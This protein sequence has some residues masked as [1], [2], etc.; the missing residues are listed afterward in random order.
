MVMNDELNE[1]HQI[2]TRNIQEVLMH[3]EKLDQLS[4]M[5]SHLASE[6]RAYADKAGDLNRRQALI[7]EWPWAPV[8]VVLGVVLLVFWLKIKLY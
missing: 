3:G 1:V 4:Q 7:R 8:A 6:T 5:T 2:M